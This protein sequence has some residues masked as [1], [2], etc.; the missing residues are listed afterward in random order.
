MS[1]NTNP[2]ALKPPDDEFLMWVIEDTDLGPELAVSPAGPP[3]YHIGPS[4]D[5]TLAELQQRLASTRDNWQ[6]V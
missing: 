1:V 2:T 3:H 5:M 4:R 6:R